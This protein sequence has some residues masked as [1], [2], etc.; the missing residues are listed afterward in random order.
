MVHREGKVLEHA[1]S[2][3]NKGRQ[4][5]KAKAAAGKKRV[6][7][8]G[9]SFL[10]QRD[11]GNPTK[12]VRALQRKCLATEYGVKDKRL[13]RRGK[14]ETRK[15]SREGLEGSGHPEAHELQATNRGRVG[16]KKTL[17]FSVD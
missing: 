10:A 1:K 8:R 11:R 5:Q 13:K 12:K 9:P 15:D 3:G 16:W 14:K 7:P 6:Q 4:L 17:L 2:E